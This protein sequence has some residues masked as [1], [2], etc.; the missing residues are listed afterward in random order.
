MVKQ[1]D[2]FDP[3]SKVLLHRVVQETSQISFKQLS[4][5]NFSEDSEFL[6]VALIAIPID[7]HFRAHK[8]LERSRNILNLRAQESWV[9]ISGKVEVTYYSESGVSLGSHVLVRG[10]CSITFRGGHSYRSLDEQA[11]VFE[12]K[13]GPYEG[14]E[15]DKRFLD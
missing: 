8:H 11:L 1:T 15:V 6:Q 12:F 9:V 5:A 2:I 7:T 10:D 4:R 3:S 13:N 14:V